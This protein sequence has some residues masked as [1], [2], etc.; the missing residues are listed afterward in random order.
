M[1]GF[2]LLRVPMHPPPDSSAAGIPQRQG[3]AER[4]A[5]IGVFDSGVGGLS[6]LRALR[7]RMPHEHF[8]YLAD[9]SHAPYGEKGDALVQQRS[10][11][12]ARFL[13]QRH[14]IKAFVVACN[15]ATA[16]AVQLL[17]SELPGLPIVGVEPALKP[18]AAHSRT[19]HVGVLATRGTVTSERFAR[20]LAAQGSGTQ[21]AIQACDGLAWAIEQSTAAPADDAQAQARI[22]ALCARYVHALGNLG[23]QPGQIDTLVLGCTHYVFAL[24]WLQDLAGPQV[25]IIE[26]GPAVARH[27]HQLLAQRDLL[28]HRDTAGATTLLTTGALAA[29]ASAAQRWL[30]L[31]AAHCAAAEVE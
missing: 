21:F 19:H 18:A 10:L 2:D 24:P 3:V 29:L 9:S 31:D 20:L 15:T 26:T 5:P 14:Q 6:V 30:A 13:H 4:D 25:Q 17:R 16:A 7:N 11:T 12:I 22:Q 27:T 8:V 23:E 28:A 1:A